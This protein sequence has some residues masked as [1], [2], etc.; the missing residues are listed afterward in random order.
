MTVSNI[1]AS[2][3]NLNLHFKGSRDYLH[4]TDLWNAVASALFTKSSACG[5]QMSINFRRVVSQAP[6]LVP[7]GADVL[8]DKFAD[9]IVAKHGI[10]HKFVLIETTDKITKRLEDKEKFIFHRTK[11]KNNCCVYHGPTV[12]TPIEVIV[13]MTKLY[14]IERVDRDISWLATRISLPV[15]FDLTANKVLEIHLKH[16]LSTLA[17]KSSIIC[18]GR[19]IGEITFNPRP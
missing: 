13:A 8:P 6:R 18:E 4:S 10:T 19:V 12:A 15:L 17:T 9:L 5:W 14:H 3:M 2:G 7:L 1:E 16:R 11:I